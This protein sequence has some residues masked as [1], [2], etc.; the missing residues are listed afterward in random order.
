MRGKELQALDLG[1]GLWFFTETQL[2]EAT[3]PS[4]RRS[5]QLGARQQHRQYTGHHGRSGTL[6][7]EFFMGRGVD[8][9]VSARGFSV[10]GAQGDVARHGI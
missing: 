2:S 10:S 9:G 5:L 1:P 8:W 4:V 7:T 3:M 6:E